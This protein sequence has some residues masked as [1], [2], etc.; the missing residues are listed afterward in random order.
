MSI[1]AISDL[2]L[3][4]SID[5]PMDIFGERWYNYMDRLRQN[6][7]K[8]VKDEDYIII[9]GDISWATYLEQAYED[10]NFIESLPGKKI[11]SK[12]NHDYWWT[13]LSKLNKFLDANNFKTISF[14]HNNSYYIEGNTICGTR[15]WKCPGDDEFNKEDEKIY[16]REL[17]RL[18]LSLKS[19]SSGTTT[20]NVIV[21]MHYPPFNAKKE[22]SEFVEIMRKYNVRKCLYGHLH[23]AGFKSAVTGEFDGIEFNLVSADFLNFEPLKL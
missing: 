13:T 5:K 22:P 18:E 4:L 20:E 15:G 8:V 11:I 7:I 12:G 16:E 21:A 3:A 1:F 14:M 10:F 23:G 17:H 9:P 6:W 19:F 2:H